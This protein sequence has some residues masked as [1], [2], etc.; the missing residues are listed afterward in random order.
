MKTITTAFCT[1][2][3]FLLVQNLTAQNSVSGM[4][5]DANSDPLI[6]ATI[7]VQGTG[8]GTITD[9]TGHY[10]LANLADDA[11]LLFSYV[12]M[13]ESIASLDGR[14]TIDISLS[15]VTGLEEVVVTALGIRR[16]ERS[17]GY[18]VGRVDGENLNRV[19]QENVL[20][21]LAGKVSG[22][23]INSTAGAGSSVSMVI[24]G[25]NSLNG[26]NQPLFVVD[27]VPIANTLNNVSQVGRDNRVDFGNAISD[28]NPDDIADISILKGPSAAA[29]YGSRAGNGVV[30]ITTKSAA[31]NGGLRVNFNSN[32][33]FDNPVKY[34]NFHSSYATGVRPYTPENNP[35]P[36]GQLYIEEGSAAGIGPKLDQGFT[37]VQWNSPLDDNGNPI[38][39]PLVSHPDNIKNFVQTGINATNNLAISNTNDIL[40]YRLSYTNMTSRG[41]IPNSD[42]FKNSV[43]LGSDVNVTKNFKVSTNLN[44][45]R[46]HSN[47]RPAGNRGSNP[48]EWAYKVSPHIDILELQD[49]W[50]EGQENIQQRSQAPGDYNNPYFLANEAINSFA[51]DRLYGNVRAE[52]QLTPKL[53][54]MARYSLDRFNEGRETRIAPSYTREA[55]GT[56]GLINLDR[57]EKNTDFLATYTTDVQDF[58]ISASAGGNLLKQKTSNIRNAT[59]QRGSGL[60]VPGLYSLSNIAPLN[61]EF[62]NFRSEKAIYSLY[63]L[64]NIGYKDLVYLDV[65]GRNDW[66][67]TLPAANRSYFYPSAALS[68]LLNNVFDLPAFSLWKLRAGWAQV[69][70]DTDPYSLAPTLGNAGAWD[71]I[72][73]L[74]KSGSL[75]T[76]DLKPEISTSF[77]IGTDIQL[78]NGRLRFEG[79]YYTV[80]NENQILGLNLPASTGYNAKTINAGLVSSTGWEV[81]IG[82]T[83]IQNAHLQWDVNLNLYRNRTKI[84]ELTEGIDRFQMW[85]D[86]KGGAWTY[87]GETIGDIY[88]AELITVTDPASPYFGYPI[89]DD[90]GSWQDIDDQDTKNKIGNFNPDFILGA[91]S[92]LTYKGFS[93]NVTVDW[94][95]G[96]QFVSQTYRYSESDLKTQ[97]F[98]DNLIVFDGSPDQLPQWLKDNASEHI[99]DGI[100]IVGG[101]GSEFG[102]QPLEFG[103]VVNDG[104]FNPG[105]LAEYDEAG[106]ITGY[107]ENL[108]GP[109][110]KYIPYA[111][112][113]PWS[114]TSAATFDADFLKLREISFGYRLPRTLTNRLK[115]QNIDVALY[116]RNVMLWTKAKVG[117]DPENAFQPEGGAQ[118]NGITFKQGIERYNVNPWVI[119]VGIKLGVTF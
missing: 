67:S 112:N 89:L 63:G 29:L 108:G 91:Q 57:S 97:R 103:V 18:S 20:N 31:K 64:I 83:P 99:T 17:L 26:D 65:T 28:L 100:N 47:N 111:A 27:G 2:L 6:G 45:G 37:A 9:E 48:L 102:G 73:R 8:E 94:R 40:S 52:W 46:T 77:E 56:Y 84:E 116:S 23:T 74:S 14:S 70:N 109:G 110:T 7:L 114:F 78:F 72:T 13:A 62:S 96:G 101:P 76:A 55:N 50:V 42:L 33:V 5:T 16:N 118:G 117:I 71:G 92:S 59:K 11:V 79:T 4:V 106:N 30:L 105:V 115:L 25:A 3:L 51:R 58:S 98:L 38:P 107:T 61:L 49:Y 21:G 66:S 36:G 95:K 69:G 34:L 68:V 43:S 86:A 81:S 113:Y 90:E 32:T 87:V 35:Y 1:L 44:V 54:L 12:G 75:L 41:L 82:G 80:D 24:R 10:E 15:D 85:R 19:A 39:L 93:L 88:D 60:I 104:V 22:V 53:S 119:P